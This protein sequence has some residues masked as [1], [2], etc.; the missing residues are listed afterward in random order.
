MILMRIFRNEVLDTVLIASRLLWN[1]S[2][3]YV[4]MFIVLLGLFGLIAWTV[5]SQEDHATHNLADIPVDN[6]GQKWRIG[7]SETDP[8][9]NF[10][11]TFYY[12]V[13]HLESEGWLSNTEDLPYTLG[14][15]DSKEM[16]E[17]L[18]SRDVG[19]YIEFVANAHYSLLISD[20]NVEEEMMKRLSEEK[21]IDLMLVMGTYAGQVVATDQHTVPTMVF[22]ASNAVQ[23]EIITSEMYSGHDHIWAHMD[24]E[25]YQRQVH[26]FHDIFAFEKLGMIFEDSEIGRIIAAYDDV[27]EV[28]RERDFEIMKE[29]VAEP[30]SS[31]PSEYDSYYHDLLEASETLAQE[32]D[33]LYLSFGVWEIEDLPNILQPFHEQNVPIFS[34]LGS[35]EVMHGALMSVSRADF[36]GIGLFG[37]HNIDQLFRGAK[38]GE[39]PQVYGDTPSITLN[40]EVA[41]KIGYQPPFEI[42]LVADD[43][44]QSINK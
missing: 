36:S 20:G 22:S 28:A 9:S 30:T 14:Q 39:L 24:A 16:W 43:V 11:G 21:D 12:L 38:L 37:V 26:V 40:L 33:A 3:K 34:Q 13:Q 18:A 1:R 29:H 35:E 2:K 7:Y 32:V 27:L 25:R 19:D 10:A 8:F 41:E 15:S 23:S 5:N 44:Y 42:L 17:W 4:M 31:D 6:E